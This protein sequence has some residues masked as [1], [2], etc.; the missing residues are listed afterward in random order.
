MKQINDLWETI[1]EIP[2]LVCH[3]QANAT[4]GQ[5]A[6]DIDAAVRHCLGDDRFTAPGFLYQAQRFEATVAAVKRQI[7]PHFRVIAAAENADRIL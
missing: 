5:F 3:W 7:E 2:A 6:G 4:T 1:H